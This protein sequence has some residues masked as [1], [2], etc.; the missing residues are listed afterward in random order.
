MTKKKRV[1]KKKDVIQKD[2][3][4]A[5]ESHW[6]RQA[7]PLQPNG[8]PPTFGTR[9]ESTVTFT[10]G[11]AQAIFNI[12]KKVCDQLKISNMLFEKSKEF[13]ESQGF[14]NIVFANAIYDKANKYMVKAKEY[15]LKNIPESKDQ[16]YKVDFTNNTL[17]IIPPAVPKGQ[18]CFM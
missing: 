16:T 17:E 14:W 15:I 8:L 2:I 1:A 5:M 6:K 4:Q 3:D 11:Q 13:R 10:A 18:E 9:R 7:I 12:P